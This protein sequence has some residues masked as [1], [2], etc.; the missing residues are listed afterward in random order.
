MLKLWKKCVLF[1]SN[2]Y[3]VPFVDGPQLTSFRAALCS[4]SLRLILSVT[5]VKCHNCEHALFFLTGEKRDNHS[6]KNKF[7]KDWHVRQ[8]K[9]SENGITMAKQW[10]KSSPFC[11]SA[12]WLSNGAFSLLF[13]TSKWMFRDSFGADPSVS[14]QN[15]WNKFEAFQLFFRGLDFSK[16]AK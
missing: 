11:H 15:H 9:K 5:I 2:K 8:A 1:D 14:L 16:A 4:Q 10:L 12:T 3:I 7:V 13:C 6:W